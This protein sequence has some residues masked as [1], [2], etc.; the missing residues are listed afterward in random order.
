MSPLGGIMHLIWLSRANT[1][2]R[3]KS[4]ALNLA[5][6]QGFLV[7]VQSSFGCNVALCCRSWARARLG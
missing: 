4:A 2:R 6:F 1:E 5:D 3:A 7:Q